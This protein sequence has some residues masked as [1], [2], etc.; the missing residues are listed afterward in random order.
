M[1]DFTIEE[2]IVFEG[3]YD[4]PGFIQAMKDQT[5]AELVEQIKEGIIVGIEAQ[6]VSLAMARAMKPI[7]SSDNPTRVW[8][9]TQL[10]CM[11]HKGT[12]KDA[13]DVYINGL[14]PAAQAALVDQK[15]QL[16]PS[17]NTCSWPVSPFALQWVIW[18]VNNAA[19]LQKCMDEQVYNL[20]G[21]KMW[22]AG[23]VA[24][25]IINKRIGVKTRYVMGKPVVD[26]YPKKNWRKT[27]NPLG[28]PASELLR[29]V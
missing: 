20:H 14:L 23:E 28:R 3:K 1:G 9:K 11:S 21:Y 10:W 15:D 29:P 7:L 12:M 18:C 17:G 4:W 19:C 8:I 24:N 13:Y 16:L 25:G 27:P 6:E 2:N 22:Q 26:Y 5:D